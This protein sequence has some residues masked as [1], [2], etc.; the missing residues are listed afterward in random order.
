MPGTGTATLDFGAG[1]NEASAAFADV[2][3]TATSKVEAFFMGAD[4]SVDHTANDHKYAPVFISLTAA[5]TDGVGGTIYG[6]SIEKVTGEW[7]V[8]YVWA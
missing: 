5:P 8:R 2:S 3:V 1:L 6:R 4:T 7:T